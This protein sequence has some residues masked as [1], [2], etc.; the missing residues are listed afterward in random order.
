MDHI[1]FYLDVLITH[2]TS[3][4]IMTLGATLISGFDYNREMLDKFE[5]MKHDGAAEAKLE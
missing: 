4:A 2:T 3:T 1:H 5:K